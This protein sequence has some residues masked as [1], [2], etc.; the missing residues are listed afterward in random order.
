MATSS[1]DGVTAMAMLFNGGAMIYGM[2]RD[3]VTSFDSGVMITIGGGAHKTHP[4]S[5][6]ATL[7]H[8]LQDLVAPLSF[9]KAFH[10]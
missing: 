8:L 10:H 7:G 3:M 9:W 6:A 2:A 4:P 1:S 5:L